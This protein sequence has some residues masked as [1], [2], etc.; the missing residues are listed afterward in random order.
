MA[1]CIRTGAS[2]AIGGCVPVLVLKEGTMDLRQYFQKIRTIAATIPGE[3]AV[4]VSLET[5]DGGREGQFSEVSRAIAAKLVAEGKGR[6]ANEQETKEFKATIRQAKK[7]A[8]E[9]SMR[10]RVQLSVLNEADVK[11][12]RNVLRKEA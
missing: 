11:L 4:V 10:D 7:A 8:D 2:A 9:L 3:H 6:L 12:L 1:P 5:Q